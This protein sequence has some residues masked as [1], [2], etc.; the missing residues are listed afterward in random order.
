LHGVRT[1]YELYKELDMR[2]STIHHALKQLAKHGMLRS[3]QRKRREG[4]RQVIPYHLTTLGLLIALAMNHDSRKMRRIVEIWPE[5]CP[6]ILLNWK[7]LSDYLG[8][9]Y[10]RDR[11]L[12]TAFTILSGEIPP[13]Y[14][15][16]Y[17][18]PIDYADLFTTVFLNPSLVAETLESAPREKERLVRAVC[19]VPELR[20]ELSEKLK[21]FEGRYSS[22]LDMVRHLQHVVETELAAHARAGQ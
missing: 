20:G 5:V 18:E 16:R 8:N 11:V 1:E 2:G 13:P 17:R 3:V 4:V 19:G 10:F 15:I 14:E 6:R 9:K 12:G 7:Q 22:L 21:L